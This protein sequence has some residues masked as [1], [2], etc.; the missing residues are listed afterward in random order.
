[1]K[2]AK[3]LL[4]LVIVI[5]TFCGILAFKAN[6]LL[7]T[8]YSLGSTT[9]NGQGTKGCVVPVDLNLTPNP[10]G[11]VTPYSSTFNAPTTTCTCRVINS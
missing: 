8:F 11:F 4:T 2:K 6:K 10:G 5:S 7:R 3:F 9:I 1:M